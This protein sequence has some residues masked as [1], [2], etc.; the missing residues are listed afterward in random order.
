M[1]TMQTAVDDFEQALEPLVHAQEPGGLGCG[2]RCQRR[3]RAAA[4]GGVEEGRCGAC[5]AGSLR[6][7]RRGRP[8]RGRR[9]AVH[10]PRAPGASGQRGLPAR[11]L[12]GGS[13]HRGR[14]SSGLAVLAPPGQ[15]RRARR[16]R[17]RD[18]EDPARVVGPRAPAPGLG[19]LEG[20]RPRRRAPRARARAPAQRGGPRARLSRSLRLLADARRARRDL[21]ARAARRSRQPARG[22]LGAHQGGDRPGTARAARP[23]GRRDAA[24]L[25]LR[26]RVLPGPADRK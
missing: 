22:D 15:D 1:Q 20:D 21:A 4:R 3:A 5:R 18:R 26:R 6:A 7:T 19:R 17:Q 16:Q 23:R 13:H 2:D 14:G 8:G 24:S 11:A 9:C 10:A 25:G 12:P